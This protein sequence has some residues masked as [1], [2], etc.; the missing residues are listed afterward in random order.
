MGSVVSFCSFLWASEVRPPCPR[1]LRGN[2]VV[3][4]ARFQA[5]LRHLLVTASE[6]ILSREWLCGQ[7]RVSSSTQ[8]FDLVRNCLGEYRQHRLEPWMQRFGC[9]PGGALIPF[10]GSVSHPVLCA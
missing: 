6:L 1:T 3:V 4:E 10:S 8:Q 7:W 2:W 9:N 5:E